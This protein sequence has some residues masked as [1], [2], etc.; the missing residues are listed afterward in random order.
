[1]PTVLIADSDDTAR[2]LLAQTLRDE[3]YEVVEARDG[4]A[5]IAQAA[6][7]DLIFLDV[8][9]PDVGGREML[10]TIRNTPALCRTP[11]ILLSALLE[12]GDCYYETDKFPAG[13]TVFLLKPVRTTELL[14]SIR[15]LLRARAHQK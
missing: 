4:T 15:M 8:N 6:R 13:Y 9:M 3:G 10:S 11:V 2:V 12:S 14:S 1:M 7:A 5:A